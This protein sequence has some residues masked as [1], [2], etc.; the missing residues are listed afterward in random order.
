MD[1][2]P[3]EKRSD[4]MRRVHSTDTTPERKV[5]TL[6]H[7]LGYR[8]RLHRKDLPGKPDI[9]LPKRRAVVFVHGCFWHRHQDCPRASTP[10]SRQEY[11]LP[12]FRRTIERDIKNQEELRKSGWNVVVVWECEIRDLEKLRERMSELIS[13]YTSNLQ[14]SFSPMA[15]AA[16]DR[17]KYRSQTASPVSQSPA[18]D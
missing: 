7:G 17:G 13:K 4:I 1:T 15:I 8:F 12:K 2:F 14:P 3:P 11:W 6:L 10:M 5:R 18:P 9:V 16:E